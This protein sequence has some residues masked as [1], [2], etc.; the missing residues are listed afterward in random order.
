[1]VRYIFRDP[2]LAIEDCVLGLRDDKG[3]PREKIDS[4]LAKLKEHA[5]GYYRRLFGEIING[6]VDAN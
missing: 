4:F 6:I 3:E 2:D 5:I 1:M